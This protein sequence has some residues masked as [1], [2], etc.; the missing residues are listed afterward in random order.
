MAIS[1]LCL[2]V[3]YGNRDVAYTFEL[4]VVHDANPLLDQI[5]HSIFMFYGD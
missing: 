1:S 3:F 4:F 5:E 2:R